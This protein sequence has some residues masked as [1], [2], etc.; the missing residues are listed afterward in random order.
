VPPP[1][2]PT[3]ARRALDSAYF[4]N[5]LRPVAYLDETYRVERG[6]PTYYV[7]AAAVMQADQRDI[8]RADVQRIVGSGYWHTTEALQTTAGT[9]R[10][11]ELLDYLGDPA[12][13]EACFIAYEHPV[14]PDD[15][16]GERARSA[17]LKALLGH[18]NGAAVE[19]VEL[20]VLEKRLTARMTNQDAHTKDSAIKDGLVTPRTRLF[21]TSPSDESLLWIPDLVCSAYR[22]RITGRRRDLFDRISGICTILL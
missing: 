7:M 14:Q 17:C 3:P 10:V 18:L 5:S 16:H 6:G 4:Y 2:A 9:A 8:V 21:Q 13:T 1:P 12:G 20:F 15:P 11:C 19:P 22:Q